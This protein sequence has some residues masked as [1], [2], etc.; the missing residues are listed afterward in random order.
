MHGRLTGD[1]RGK[2]DERG[3]RGAVAMMVAV[4]MTSLLIIAAIVLD[5]GLVRI[6]RQVDKSA[7]DAAALAGAH[8][9]NT[10][11]GSPHPYVGVCS[12][13]TYL[14]SN[15]D[16][17][18][19]LDTTT[20]WSNGAGVATANG[21]ADLSLRSKLC[22]AS[23]S[24]TWATW[25]GSTTYGGLRLTVSIQSAYVI[26]AGQWTEDSLPASSV[27][28]GDPAYG[29]CDQ[30]AVV[31]NQSRR[32]GL[33]S[34]ATTSDLTTAVRSVARIQAVPG[35]SAPAMLLLK[36]TGCP[37]LTTGSNGG[38]SYVH[39]LGSVS[40]DGRSQP[41]TVHSDSDGLGCNGGNNSWIFGGLASDGIVAYAAPLVANPTQ[42]DPSKPGQ[43]TAVAAAN[44]IT[45]S[46]LR[47][48]N[49]N[50]YGS[51]LLD[52][53]GGTHT[54]VGTK[55]LVTRRL[56]DERYFT[57]VR[58]AITTANGLFSAGAAGVP[59]GWTSLSAA[60]VCQ[61]TQAEVTAGVALA[62]ANSGG[63]LY[64]GCASSGGNG[65]QGTGPTLTIGA[66]QVYFQGKVAPASNVALSLPNA[67]KV[68]VGNKFAKPDAIS[69]SNGTS[70]SVNNSPLNLDATTGNCAAGQSSSKAL[71]VIRDGQFKQTGGLL[72]MCRTTTLMLGGQADGCVPASSG[73]APLALP[74]T[75][76]LGT[77]QF[78]Q[79]G[80]GIDWT[81]PDTL[82]ATRDAT[83]G[84]PLPA[85]TTAWQNPD[86]PED[87]ALWSESGTNSSTNFSMA[88]GG[89]FRVRGVFMVPN[90][91]SFILS[92]GSHLDLTNAQFIASSITLNGNTTSVTMSVDP[93]SAVTLPDQGVV[94]LVR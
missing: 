38:S 27:D 89:L 58:A 32:P 59:S 36:R 84:N 46:P 7:A 1:R 92:G 76:T 31:I 70:F 20:G 61:P 69:I 62:N 57:G 90:A 25:R 48:S 93:N 19:G 51:S 65:F 8:G 88:G 64:I 42:P 6:D 33:G 10:G 60:N 79:Q 3:E 75:G 39:V 91:D 35:D 49:T 56:I 30:L 44:G 12:A 34:L 41:G 22:K 2:R 11:D 81:A 72:R 26:P 28:P 14:K 74:C 50:V 94:G 87:L 5:F 77:G 82:D 45:G 80:G 52:G 43:I 15:G 68:Y 86:G 23:D 37:V 16:R 71:M 55:S 40:S 24:S 53:V 85:A 13:L 67:T 83:T 54:D 4:S 73:S 66:S 78:T 18:A 17:F 47:D 21:C 63:R 29:G 9:L